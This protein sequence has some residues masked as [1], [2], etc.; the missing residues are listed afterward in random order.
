MLAAHLSRFAGARAR[1][2]ES[3]SARN[4]LP[5][6]S[7]GRALAWVMLAYGTLGAVG[8]FVALALGHDP[9]ATTAWLPVEGAFAAGV[10]VG[11]GLAVAAVT[12]AATRSMVARAAWARELHADLRPVVHGADDAVIFL[13]AMASGVGEELFFRGMLVPLVGAWLSAAAFGL[14]HQVRGRARWAW[15]AWA[16]IMGMVFAAIFQLTGHLEGAI[17]A[18]VAINTANLRFLRDSEPSPKSR[19]ALGGLLGR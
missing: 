9:W 19:P 5:A 16:A 2:A 3:A 15:A 11:L 13:T 6:R 4:A 18:H 1:V 14:L 17:V 12:V 7:G 10:S 8:A